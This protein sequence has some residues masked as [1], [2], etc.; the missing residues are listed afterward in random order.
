M[1]L[2]LVAFIEPRAVQTFYKRYPFKKSNIYTLSTFISFY[3]IFQ[4]LYRIMYRVKIK[5]ISIANYR[6]NLQ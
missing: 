3:N 6:L 1:F 2:I 4:P 5:S